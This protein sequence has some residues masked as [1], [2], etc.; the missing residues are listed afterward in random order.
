MAVISFL[1]E[2]VSKSCDIN[3]RINFHPN[4][5]PL[6]QRWNYWRQFSQLGGKNFGSWS[7]SNMGRSLYVVESSLKKIQISAKIRIQTNVVIVHLSTQSPTLNRLQCI[8]VQRSYFYW[9]L[10]KTLKI[11]ALI[12]L[13]LFR[14]GDLPF[15]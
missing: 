5:I 6:E 14:L 7:S 2:I 10:V 4:H 9:I 13:D 11:F 3:I 15:S 12:T 8:L 1:K